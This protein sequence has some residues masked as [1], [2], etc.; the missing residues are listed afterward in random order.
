MSTSSHFVYL[1]ENFLR[2]LSLLRIGLAT[3][4]GV[5][6]PKRYYYSPSDLDAFAL[7]ACAYDWTF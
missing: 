2:S 7:N 6:Y 5:Y 4:S 1:I 3:D